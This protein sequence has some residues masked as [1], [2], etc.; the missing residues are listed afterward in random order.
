MTDTPTPQDYADIN[1]NIV[2]SLYTVR[3]SPSTFDGPVDRPLARVGKRE[4]VRR[5]IRKHAEEQAELTDDDPDVLEAYF[6]KLLEGDLVVGDGPA[7]RADQMLE[8]IAHDMRRSA[9][10]R[11][12]EEPRMST[13]SAFAFVTHLRIRKKHYE[14]RLSSG[15]E[16]CYRRWEALLRETGVPGSN[17]P[18]LFG[19]LVA[20]KGRWVKFVP[21]NTLTEEERTSQA[22]AAQE[23]TDV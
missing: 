7:V 1:S 19:V 13:P 2:E 4:T 10:L 8:D 3:A 9:Q 18:E 12:S 23:A 6:H 21:R 14:V 15:Q 20:N 22:A 16:K 5:A 11:M 17:G